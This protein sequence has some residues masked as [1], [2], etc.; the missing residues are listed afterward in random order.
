MQKKK[1]RKWLQ[2]GASLVEYSLL[3][4]LISVVAIA[5]VRRYGRTINCRHCY[6]ALIVAHPQV[7]SDPSNPRSAL[8]Q[9]CQDMFDSEG[10][11]CPSA[12]Q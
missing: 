2:M 10:P 1:G 3:I 9:H 7:A 4:A 12:W 5:S 11:A 6:N 8:M